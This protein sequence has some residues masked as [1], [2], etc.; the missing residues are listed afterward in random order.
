MNVFVIIIV[1]Y[2]ELCEDIIPEIINGAIFYTPPR[3]VSATLPPGQRYTG[4]IATY[5]CS[6]GY[7]LVGGSL[8]R[9]CGLGGNWSGMQ[10]FCG[11]LIS[12]HYLLGADFEILELYAQ[13]TYKLLIY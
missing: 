13:D 2:T 11:N 8:L 6:P 12:K 7:Q 1:I 3:N 10:T 9:V 4:T 5:S